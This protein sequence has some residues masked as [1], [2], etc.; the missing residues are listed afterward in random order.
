MEKRFKHEST[1]T[2]NF[3]RPTVSDPKP[4]SPDDEFQF[5]AFCAQT[6]LQH[7][8]L[9][10]FG[11]CILPVFNDD[12]ARQLL[13]SGTPITSAP[14]EI[15][16][17]LHELF[18]S[19]E[20][21][22]VFLEKFFTRKQLHAESIDQYATVLR[23]LATKAYPT[24]SKEERDCQI[25]Q[26]FIV[27][28]SENIIKARFLEKVP[29][30]LTSALHKSRTREAPTKALR[31]T[32]DRI[33]TVVVATET[34]QPTF[35]M[36]PQT[37]P[38]PQPGCRHC[39]KFGVRAQ[40]CGHNAPIGRLGE[41]AY[42]SITLHSILTDSKMFGLPLTVRGIVDGMYTETLVESGAAC[43]IVH[44]ALARPSF[45][46]E[47]HLRLT[48]TN[49]AHLVS[50][51]YTTCNVVLGAFSTTHKFECA[52]TPWRVLSGMDFLL[53]HKAII[54]LDDESLHLDQYR[55]ALGLTVAPLVKDKPEWVAEVLLSNGIEPSGREMNGRPNDERASCSEWAKLEIINGVLQIREQGDLLRIVAPRAKVQQLIKR[56]H[57]QLVHPGQYRTHAAMVQRY[58][59]PELR[60][61]VIRFCSQYEVCARNK[62]SKKP[63]MTPCNHAIDRNGRP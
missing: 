12:A 49:G 60:Q 48:A 32:H 19:H 7:V 30:S 44:P 58:W 42:Q 27:E 62:G 35:T 52:E 39:Q 11:Q 31:E 38:R 37:R 41:S 10:H 51:G 18:S 46:G 55:L 40:H 14:D 4:F 29:R 43:S 8:P 6:Y 33:V 59:W 56:T 63:S 25:Q 61:D 1:T 50:T 24:V 21:A 3:I 22:P 13:A 45:S 34:R 17:A 5:W 54:D 20:L 2:E 47:G 23:Q 28:V 26:L 53:K 9:E 16:V 15:W 57:H 36:R